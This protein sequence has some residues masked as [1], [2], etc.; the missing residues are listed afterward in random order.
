MLEPMAESGRL[1]HTTAMVL[2][3]IG[4]GQAYGY[5]IMNATGLPSGTVYPVLRRLE[6]DGWIRAEREPE[7]VAE[8]EQRPPRKSYR[9]TPAGW[10][11]L[12]GAGKRYPLL[13]RLIP[14]EQLEDV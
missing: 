7:A 13:A 14:S 2:R 4:L 3:A 8:A 5:T 6:G 9:L 10:A 11:A 12:D 1:T